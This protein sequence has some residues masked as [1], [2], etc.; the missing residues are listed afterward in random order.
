[1]QK[2][3]DGYGT[4]WHKQMHQ[5]NNN[6]RDNFN[7]C[8]SPTIYPSTY[9]K[10]HTNK[11][12]KDP[13]RSISAAFKHQQDT[14]CVL[15]DSKCK[16]KQA[17]SFDMAVSENGFQSSPKLQLQFCHVTSSPCSDPF[18][19][20]KETLTVVKREEQRSSSLSSG[21]YGRRSPTMTSTDLPLLVF[22]KVLTSPST[23]SSTTFPDITSETTAATMLEPLLYSDRK[24]SPIADSEQKQLA[25]R[26]NDWV[27]IPVFADIVQLA[28]TGREECLQK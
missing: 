10:S 23:Q 3:A 16:E 26:P 7:N 27:V 4:L 24:L 9:R 22:S 20:E 6:Q 8:P 14:T 5:L 1:M 25:K 19:L 17:N 28:L 18:P 2:H 12:A 13:E 21:S 15:P 11:P